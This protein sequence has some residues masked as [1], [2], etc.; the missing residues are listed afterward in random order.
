MLATKPSSKRPWTLDITREELRL[1]LR[2]RIGKAANYRPKPGAE[3]STK[4]CLWDIALLARAHLRSVRNFAD[5]KPH[6]PGYATAGQKTLRRVNEILDL[7]NGG[8][9]TK[10]QYGAYH[11]WDDP[12]VP[13][14]VT[15]RINLDTGRIMGGISTP[16]KPQRMPSF[17][18]VFGS[19]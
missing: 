9:I 3:K 15:R 7:V 6:I 17:G 12:H 4:I 16:K 1:K 19:K 13:P 8:Y 10:T 14:V 18:T 11:F 2:R 5:G